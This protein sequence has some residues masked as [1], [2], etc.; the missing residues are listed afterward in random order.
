MSNFGIKKS[1]DLHTSIFSNYSKKLKLFLN[2]SFTCSGKKSVI[3]IT[4]FLGS[5][6]I[7]GRISWIHYSVTGWKF[8]KI[9]TWFLNSWKPNCSPFFQTNFEYLLLALENFSTC[10]NQIYWN[11]QK[12]FFL[13]IQFFVWKF[14]IKLVHY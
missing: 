5:G 9:L 11:T 7:L 13:T 2:Y 14:S 4:E 3:K 6:Q 10:H 1:L 8:K 12:H